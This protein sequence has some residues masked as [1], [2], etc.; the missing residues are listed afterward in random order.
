MPYSTL[1]SEA[2]ISSSNIDFKIIGVIMPISSKIFSFFLVDN[3]S[4]KLKELF[5]L[6]YIKIKG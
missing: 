4:I 2:E 1:I 5:L 3:F 6:I